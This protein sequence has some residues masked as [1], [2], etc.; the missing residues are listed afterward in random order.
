MNHREIRKKNPQRLSKIH[1]F[2]DKY[3]WK[4]INF[5]TGIRDWEKFE[6]NNRNIALNIL[7]VPPSTE[8]I[9]IAYKSKYNRK[10]KD[11][12]A[13]LMITDNNQ[14]NTE[15]KWHYIALKSI[16]TDDGFSRP[17]RSISTLFRKVTSNNNVAYNHIEQIM[18]LKNTKDYAISTII[19]NR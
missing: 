11:Q 7:Y 9:N 12:V 10:R 8:E 17:T 16:P 15:D 14:E 13:L 6:R 2:I 19:A 3:N 5:P 1:S 4:D 18:H